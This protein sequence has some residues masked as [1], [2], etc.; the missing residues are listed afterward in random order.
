MYCSISDL[1]LADVLAGHP[2]RLIE[3]LPTAFGLV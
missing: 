2:E 3:G 1:M